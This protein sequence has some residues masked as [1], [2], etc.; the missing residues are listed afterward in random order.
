M[1]HLLRKE[2]PSIDSPSLSPL[3]LLG[4]IYPRFE[5]EV[6]FESGKLRFAT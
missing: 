6:R 2:L 3:L 1:V 5:L 4:L